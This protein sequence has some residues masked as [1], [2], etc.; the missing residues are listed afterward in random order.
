VKGKFVPVPFLLIEGIKTYVVGVAYNGI[1]CIR[2][3]VK[4]GQH[5][6]GNDVL[7]QTNN[8]ESA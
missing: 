7:I 8:E 5:V 1:K 3:F 2:D 6:T 4:I